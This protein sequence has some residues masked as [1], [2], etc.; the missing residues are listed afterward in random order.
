[1]QSELNTS[2]VSDD[3]TART[4]LAAA[5]PRR[6]WRAASASN[7]LDGR[8]EVVQY[9]GAM[10][11]H[12]DIPSSHWTAR[13][14]SGPLGHTR[15]WVFGADLPGPRM[16]IVGGQHGD[17]PAGH[18]VA[19]TLAARWMH[20]PPTHPTMV[21]TRANPAA[22]FMGLRGACEDAPLDFVHDLNRAWPPLEQVPARR[23]Q[24]GVSYSS[25]RDPAS[26]SAN[27]LAAW[28]TV[29]HAAILWGAIIAFRPTHALD[30][31]E[32]PDRGGGKPFAWAESAADAALAP[33]GLK[34]VIGE[35][36]RTLQRALAVTGARSLAIEVRGAGGGKVATRPL[37][38]RTREHLEIVGQVLVR[39]A[40]VPA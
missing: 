4:C 38:D 13:V 16:L 26:Y 29:R 7:A 11:D 35:S 15:S 30:L 28:P 8:D 36:R 24:A 22:L 23:A 3:V 19:W 31:H 12:I 34:V 27:E 6:P 33:V 37:A 20:E 21:I 39:V 25:A 17:E 14:L 40:E 9:Q 10:N 18:E 32:T 5:A 1:M 2:Q